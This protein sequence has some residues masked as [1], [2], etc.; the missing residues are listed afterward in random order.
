MAQRMALK[1]IRLILSLQKCL[2]A[3]LSDHRSHCL[4]TGNHQ[5]E[6]F[7]LIVQNNAQAQAILCNCIPA[8]IAADKML[9]IVHCIT[10]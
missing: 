6:I 10:K 5:S 7:K 8:P 1:T 9:Y 4:I 3:L 2:R